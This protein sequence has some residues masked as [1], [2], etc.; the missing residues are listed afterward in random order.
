MQ[1]TVSQLA[2]GAK[3]I[4]LIPETHTRNAY[5]V[6]SLQRLLNII[7]H[8]GFEARIGWSDDNPPAELSTTDGQR[9]PVYPVLQENNRLKLKGFN[10]D[11]IMLNNDLSSGLPTLYQNI[12][13]PIFPSASLGWTS[14]LKSTHFSRYQ[15]VAHEL[16]ELL[17]MDAWLITPLFKNCGD[18]DFMSRAGSDCLVK[19]AGLLLKAIQAKYDDYGIKKRPFVMVKA[20]AGTYGMGVMPIFDANILQTLN[21][22]Q[23][24]H[25]SAAKGGRAVNTVIIQEGIYSV[26]TCPDQG[27]IAEPVIYMIG[28]HVV[29]GFY[30]VHPQRETYENLN[31]PGMLFNPLAFADPLANNRFYAYSVIARLALLAAAKEME[32]Q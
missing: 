1:E 8:A 24:T 16:S 23:R 20:D 19:N 29:G 25:M 13:Q 31:T 30:R 7:T 26:E 18:I 9:L 28:R 17:H 12:T 21:R 22:K 5:Y 11:V 14:R 3:K 4:L 6:D 32:M 15:A 2:P 10:P 27:G